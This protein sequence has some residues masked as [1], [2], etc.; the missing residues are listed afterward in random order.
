MDNKPECTQTSK[1]TAYRVE[2]RSTGKPLVLD[3]WGVI[4]SEWIGM[5]TQKVINGTAMLRA[6]DDLTYTLSY[7]GAVA[8]AASF[9]SH[10]P[11]YS[12]LECR[13]VEY[14]RV[15]SYEMTKAGE[16]ELLGEIERSFSI[17]A[18]DREQQKKALG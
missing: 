2:V 7:Y 9:L 16:H 5:P 6:E 17:A 12:G 18:F 10:Y 4:G 14:R 11:Y 1:S 13:L 15:I 3:G 8:I